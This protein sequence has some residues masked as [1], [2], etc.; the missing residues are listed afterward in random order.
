MNQTVFL[1]AVGGALEQTGH[2]VAYLCFH[3]R[4]H[5]YLLERSRHS[6]NA[7]R[8]GEGAD[9]ALELSRYAWPSLNLVLSHEKAAFELGHGTAGAQAAP[10]SRCLRIRVADFGQRSGLASDLGPGAWWISVQYRQLLRRAPPRH[11]QHLHRAI[12]LSRPRV[13][14][15]Q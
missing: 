7:F 4:S 13:L 10:L 12:V 3:E 5:E 11:A 9:H 1:E 14:Y 6:F 15:V 2:R 8:E